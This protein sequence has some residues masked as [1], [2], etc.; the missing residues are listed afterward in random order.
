MCLCFLYSSKDNKHGIIRAAL[1]LMKGF[2][3]CWCKRILMSGNVNAPNLVHFKRT[4]FSREWKPGI[5]YAIVIKVT[6]CSAI[7]NTNKRIVR[8]PPNQIVFI[9]AKASS[10]AV[11]KPIGLVPLDVGRDVGG[12]VFT[13]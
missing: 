13:K 11:N 10:T 9:L 12:R 7:S 8:L 6:F 4:L 5:W 1:S 3:R 2:S